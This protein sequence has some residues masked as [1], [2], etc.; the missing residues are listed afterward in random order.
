MCGW[1]VML[2]FQN[3]FGDPAMPSG[4]ELEVVLYR[5]CHVCGPFLTSCFKALCSAIK[6]LS[7]HLP[8]TFATGWHLLLL[9]CAIGL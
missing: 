4:W 5:W 8:K 1:A 6:A 9:P 7:S 3:G 2:P